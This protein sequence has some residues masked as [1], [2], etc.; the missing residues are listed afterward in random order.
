MIKV[1][2]NSALILIAIH[3]TTYS[4]EKSDVLPDSELIQFQSRYQAHQFAIVSWINA[5]CE[6][7]DQQCEQLVTIA[8]SNMKRFT[9][10]FL[11]LRDKKDYKLGCY[12]AESPLFLGNE[13]WGLSLFDQEFRGQVLNLLFDQQREILIKQLDDRSHR[14]REACRG[15]LV[16][17]MDEELFFSPT[18]WD[19]ALIAL[20]QEKPLITHALFSFQASRWNSMGKSLF[21]EEIIPEEC[22]SDAQKRR[23]EDLKSSDHARF[24]WS[25]K[26]NSSEAEMVQQFLTEIVTSRISIYQNAFDVRLDLLSQTP[27]PSKENCRQ[28]KLASEG[29]L[30]RTL[31]ATRN[32]MLPYFQQREED[33]RKSFY[34]S[35]VDEIDRD[36]LWISTLSKADFAPVL[37]G[38]QNRQNLAN[39]N[40][41]IAL[42]DQE[43]WLT[44]EQ[45]QRLAQ[46]ISSQNNQSPSSSI[47][48]KVS[49]NFPEML[50]LAR[51]VLSTTETERDKWLSPSQIS[52]FKELSNQFEIHNETLC[53]RIRGGGLLPLGSMR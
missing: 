48:N 20:R 6:L 38:R 10:E 16:A 4:Q 31:F 22:L 45:S 7:N 21:D 32:L 36:P 3:E 26:Q 28:L 43:L 34:L 29:A 9:Q 42:L 50:A 12:L 41:L 27:Q 39:L 11:K 53:V 15:R 35:Q 25:Q 8:E 37:E 30:Q 51:V 2:L 5:T 13:T 46:K 49:S 40:Y 17:K 47:M 19:E 23:L 44:P 18:Q 24:I 52:A 1:F 14:Y 33:G